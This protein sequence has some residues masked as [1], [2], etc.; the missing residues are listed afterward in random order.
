MPYFARQNNDEVKTAHL[1]GSTE[2]E[3]SVLDLSQRSSVSACF[4]FH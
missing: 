4:N 3:H 1:R 2:F